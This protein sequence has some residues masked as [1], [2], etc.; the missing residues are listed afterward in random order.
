MNLNVLKKT[1]RKPLPGDVF[2]LQLKDGPFL[3]GRAI[4]TDASIGPIKDC[5]LIY[6]YD[7][8]SSDALP[9]PPLLRTSLLVPPLLTNLLPWSKGYFE[10]VE[11]RPLG[12][13]ERLPQHCFVDTRGW[14]F[15]E[16]SNRLPG[17]IPPVGV[18]GL[19]SYRTI[20]DKIS[21]ALGIP[22]APD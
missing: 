4:A 9:V 22:L 20:D 15:D 2:A 16:R 19:D 5:V 21:A 11:E 13:L 3:H 1:R 17:P 18:W 6:V 12:E 8:K 14:Y 7:T 10:L